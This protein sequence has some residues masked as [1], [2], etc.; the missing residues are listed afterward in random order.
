MYV[1]DLIANSFLKQANVF[2]KQVMKLLT[3]VMVEKMDCLIVLRSFIIDVPVDRS[4]TRMDGVR[5]YVTALPNVMEETARFQV[6]LVFVSAMD[7]LQ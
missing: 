3:A 1:E 4:E 6:T 7:T 2:V 5:I